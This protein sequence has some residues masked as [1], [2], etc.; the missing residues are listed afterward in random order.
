MPIYGKNLKE[1]SS[2]EPKGRWHWN[3]VCSIGCTSTT[4]F[5]QMMNLGWPRSILRLGQIWSLMLLCGDKGKTID[6]FQKLLSSMIPKL[7]DTVILMRIWNYMNIKDQ[8]HSLTLVQGLSDSK[9]SNFFSWETAR[10]IEAKFHIWI[11]HVGM[12]ER[13]FV[14]MFQVTWPRWPPCPYMVKTWKILLCNQKVDYL[15]S[16]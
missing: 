12:E 8:G 4:K 6:F 2:P 14:Q 10:P 16:W 11:L 3:L 9:Y 1:S 7:V 15:V 13:Q 5:V